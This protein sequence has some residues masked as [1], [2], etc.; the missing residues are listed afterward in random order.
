MIN[1]KLKLK[2]ISFFLLLLILFISISSITCNA[3]EEELN[4]YGNDIWKENVNIVIVSQIEGESEYK[5]SHTHFSDLTFILKNSDVNWLNLTIKIDEIYTNDLDAKE[6]DLE[7]RNISFKIRKEDNVAFVNMENHPL[8]GH[9]IGFFPFFGYCKNNN[10]EA[11]IEYMGRMSEKVTYQ[12][13]NIYYHEKEDSSVKKSIG[14]VIEYKVKED[15]I[16]IK[17]IPKFNISSPRLSNFFKGLYKVYKNRYYPIEVSCYL[18]YT[19]FF[20]TDNGKSEYILLT[21]S[22]HPTY[23][24][25]T[26]Y[27]YIKDIDIDHLHG[28]DNINNEYLNYYPVLMVAITISIASTAGYLAYKKKDL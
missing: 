11:R 3:T 18:P 26:N 27:Q 20:T 9:K 5:Y 2:I 24:N 6:I 23:Y 28:A 21:S 19:L 17:E 8:D 4:R 1:E 22:L 12:T 7:Y 25:D 14:D 16:T 13:H 15:P 10:Y